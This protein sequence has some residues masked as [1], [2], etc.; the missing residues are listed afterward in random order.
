MGKIFIIRTSKQNTEVG[1]VEKERRARNMAG[2][3]VLWHRALLP[4]I[5]KEHPQNLPYRFW[6]WLWCGNT[7]KR[8]KSKHKP[9]RGK[10]T[11]RYFSLLLC[12]V[13]LLPSTFSDSLPLAYYLNPLVI[14]L[15]SPWFLL[16]GLLRAFVKPPYPSALLWWK[17]WRK[18]L[19]WNLCGVS[20]WR[21]ACPVARVGFVLQQLAWFD[22][23]RNRYLILRTPV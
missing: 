5:Y 22:L 17:S 6:D 2:R 7:N 21:W 23:S 14:P 12:F 3:C 19:F 9:F 18:D 10:E 8:R 11:L 4:F 13:A 20:K 16:P 1:R 15:S